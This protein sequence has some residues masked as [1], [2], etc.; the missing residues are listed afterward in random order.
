MFRNVT[1]IQSDD[2]KCDESRKETLIKFCNTE[3]CLSEWRAGE[4]SECSCGN[5]GVQRRFVKNS[6]SV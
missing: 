1:C 3:K 2:Q 4:W 5:T 6:Q